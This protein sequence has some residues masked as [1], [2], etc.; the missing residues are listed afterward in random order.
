MTKQTYVSKIYFI[1]QIF[2][3]LSHFFIQMGLHKLKILLKKESSHV[4]RLAHGLKL[5][6]FFIFCCNLICLAQEKKVY[7][8]IHRTKI[9]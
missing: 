3:H 9:T 6:L 5:N 2:S 8:V 1:P 7:T 4:T